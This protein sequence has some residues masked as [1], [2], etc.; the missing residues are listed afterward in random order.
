MVEFDSSIYCFARPTHSFLG[1]SS[2]LDL[3]HAQ[4]KAPCAAGAARVR[5]SGGPDHQVLAH[6]ERLLQ[7]VHEAGAQTAHYVLLR[8]PWEVSPLFQQWLLAHFPARARYARQAV[9]QQVI[10]FF[11]YPPEVRTIEPSV[12]WTA[13]KT[14]AA[15]KIT[16]AILPSASRATGC[17][18]S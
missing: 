7:A 9:W 15:A 13:C 11:A 17:G 6:R 16:T 12:Q 1:L 14:C 3:V 4:H 10:P 18:P 8:L 5:V 2:G